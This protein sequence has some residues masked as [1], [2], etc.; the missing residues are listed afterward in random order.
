MAPRANPL[1]KQPQR[2]GARRRPSRPGRSW[3]ARIP[4]AAC[5]CTLMLY[6]HASAAGGPVLV[7][8]GTGLVNK[9]MVHLVDKIRPGDLARFSAASDN[10]LAAFDEALVRELLPEPEWEEGI[11]AM[12]GN[13]RM[14]LTDPERYLRLVQPMQRR[15]VQRLEEGVTLEPLCTGSCLGSLKP[16]PALDRAGEHAPYPKNLELREGASVT[17]ER[18]EDG[19]EVTITSPARGDE[20]AR[21]SHHICRSPQ[22][23]VCA[24]GGRSGLADAK[25]QLACG[26]LSVTTSMA[27]GITLGSSFTAGM[28]KFEGKAAVD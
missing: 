22:L 2:S 19:H 27:T 20:P 26:P 4:L 24:S 23:E 16:L 12:F 8:T 17:I 6:G 18:I 15:L 21:E 11:E 3:W 28:W 5:C 1:A 13:Q 7:K 25:V 10:D 14:D 9:V